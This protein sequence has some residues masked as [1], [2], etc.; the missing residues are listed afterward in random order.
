MTSDHD[1]ITLKDA[2]KIERDKKRARMRRWR[3]KP[4]NKE[5][6]TA[7]RRKWAKNNKDKDRASRQ[8]W[9]KSNPSTVRAQSRRRAIRKYGLTQDGYEAL[10]NSQGRQ[11]AICGAAEPGSKFDWA[12][13]HCHEHGFVR[14]ILCHHCNRIVHKRATPHILRKAANYLASHERSHDWP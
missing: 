1:T 9:R 10:F 8:K 5:K 6:E 12:I 13:D 4:G 2:A 14:G 11:C 3:A 7:I